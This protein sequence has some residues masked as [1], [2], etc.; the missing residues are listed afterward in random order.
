MGKRGPAKTSVEIHKL[1]GT[2]RRD[3]HGPRAAAA[4]P[5]AADRAEKLQPGIPPHEVPLSP[6][7]PAWLPPGAAAAYRDAV[8]HAPMGVLLAIDRDIMVVWA[9]AADILRQALRDVAG[10][11]LGTSDGL[12]KADCHMKTADRQSRLLRQ[13][14]KKCLG[15]RPGVPVQ[16]YDGDD[17]PP[18][19]A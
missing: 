2:Y 13:L 16:G 8:T 19:A 1:R 9:C 7:P 10:C 3:R 18:D 4:P 5:V 6:E 17:A 15:F 12:K 11:D 14:E